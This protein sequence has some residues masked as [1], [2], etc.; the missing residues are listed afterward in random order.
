M[1]KIIQIMQL[2]SGGICGLSDDGK[3]W[4]LRAGNVWEESEVVNP[5]LLTDAEQ[6]AAFRD[7][8]PSK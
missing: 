4:H 1:R 8:D 7:K 6:A 3:L 5:E 2:H